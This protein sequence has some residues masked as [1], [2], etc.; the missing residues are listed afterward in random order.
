MSKKLQ[1]SLIFSNL[2][3]PNPLSFDYHTYNLYT[4]FVKILE[5]CKQY[6]KKLVN[7]H[8]NIPCFSSVPKF[9]DLEVIIFSL[10]AETDSLDREKWLFENRQ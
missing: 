2:M 8:C 5:I 9:F 3:M 4:K 1:I 7:K 6:S 10:T